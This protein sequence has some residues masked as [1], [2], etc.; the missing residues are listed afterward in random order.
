ME[1]PLKEA[2]HKVS[3]F[4]P[5]KGKAQA[6]GLTLP[7][8]GDETP[9]KKV[10]T[11]QIDIKVNQEDEQK[12]KRQEAL[13]EWKKISQEENV[14]IANWKDTPIVVTENV[15]LVFA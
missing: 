11:D 13:A 2:K 3:G 15:R 8:G 1:E 10:S 12:K 5:S 6:P 7:I 4:D 14:K 9:I